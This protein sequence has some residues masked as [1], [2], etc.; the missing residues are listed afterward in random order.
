M[1]KRVRRFERRLRRS[2]NRQ[3]LII[4]VVCMLTAYAIVRT[5]GGQSFYRSYS[6]GYSSDDLIQSVAR[7]A[8][9]FELYNQKRF[10]R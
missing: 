9:A 5:T 10:A 6:E 8:D 3:N 2:M 4:A 7:V 1:Q